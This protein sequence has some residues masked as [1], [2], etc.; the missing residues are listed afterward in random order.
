LALHAE[1]SIVGYA[2]QHMGAVVAGVVDLATGEDLTAQSPGDGGG[3]LVGLSTLHIPTLPEPKILSWAAGTLLKAKT[4]IPGQ[5]PKGGGERKKITEF[6]RSSR[7]RFQ[8]LMATIQRDKIPVFVTLTYPDRFPA[9][10]ETQYKHIERLRSRLR[11]KGYGAIWRREFQVRKSGENIGK[12]APHYHLMVWGADYAQLLEYIPR[13]WYDCVGSGDIKHL[14]AG[15]RIEKIRTWRGV[16]SY[17]SK[18]M[19][20]IEDLPSLQDAESIGRFWGVINRDVIPWAEC[21]EYAVPIGIV[22]QFFRYMRRYANMR[23][24]SSWPSMTIFCAD[25]WRWLELAQFHSP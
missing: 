15:T 6:S 25:P 8:R 18:Y 16:S 2:Q 11:R 9:D 22:Y 3:A 5:A 24:R 4:G 23:G 1:Y 14:A 19:A 13:A 10:L 20:K 17:V 12:L 21:I 7:R